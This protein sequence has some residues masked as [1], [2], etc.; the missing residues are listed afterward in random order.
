MEQEIE[1][2]ASIGWFPKS[3]P[4]SCLEQHHTRDHGKKQKVSIFSLQSSC[5]KTKKVT[6]EDL[7]Q[8][9]SQKPRM[10]RLPIAVKQAK[11]KARTL[12]VPLEKPQALRIERAAG[13]DKIKDEVSRWDVVVQ[14][15][16]K[17][18]QLIFPLN[19]P[20]IKMNTVRDF[21]SKFKPKTPLEQQVTELLRGNKQ[22]Q[23]DD[24]ELTPAEQEAL[25]S[26]SL[27]EALQRRK[28]LAKSRALQSYQEAKARRQNKIKSKTYHRLLK[29]EKM[30]N[31]VKEF[32]Q[33]KE[34]DPENA[35]FKLEQLEKRRIEERM[36]LKHKGA[37]KWA[38]LQAIR[39][40]YDENAREALAD[41]LR[42]GKEVTRKVKQSD[43]E[44]EEDVPT[45]SLPHSNN[46]W[47]GGSEKTQAS[48]Q[49]TS[50]Y[51]K[52]WNTVNESKQV[53]KRNNDKGIVSE[54]VKRLKP[55]VELDQSGESTVTNK[56]N[57]T[58]LDSKEAEEEISD[59]V[60]EERLV[61][62]DKMEDFEDIV[63]EEVSTLRS[64]GTLNESSSLI[65][66]EKSQTDVSSQLR[67]GKNST[68]NIDPNKFV[69]MKEIVI[70]HSTISSLEEGNDEDDEEE[71]KRI[72]L[73]EAFA[74][75][76]VIEQFTQEKKNIV[77]SATPKD[78]DLT[79]PGWGEWAGAGVQPSKRKR[80]RFIIKAPPAPKR[81]D[82]NIGNLI[83][84]EDKNVLMRRQQVN[85]IPLSFKTVAAFEST[86]RAPVTSTFIP[87]TASRKM[88]TPKVVSKIGTVIAPMTEEIL[89]SKT[90]SSNSKTGNS[91]EEDG[92]KTRM[93]DL[94]FTDV[95]C[96]L[97]TDLIAVNFTTRCQKF[98]I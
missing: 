86:I 18:E 26:M 84:N 72:T 87:E 22:V 8:E 31:H 1:N 10:G 67:K 46:P 95:H 82:E 32:E 13:Y 85:D 7:L 78:I 83:I 69:T 75:D 97:Y 34:H 80:K 98:S 93:K 51:R 58:S 65:T 91:I 41:Q 53:K 54:S 77:N 47:L 52:L 4:T 40:K 38:K 61:R 27:K 5:P 60:L 2:G 48:S 56:N 17:A 35:L 62:N 59:V 37:G 3:I 88:T 70:H 71:R 66:A 81:K 57:G 15:N 9:V 28:E 36:T 24:Q 63:D 29:R 14:S 55:S 16:Q 50:G 12:N 79:L 68:M 43:D 89:M 21:S 30:K 23:R 11:K 90:K 92:R 33:M 96:T 39:S 6:V 44:S 76:D 94:C 74:D 25:S 64:Q 19:Q 42:I 73:A 20:S 49:I 45:V